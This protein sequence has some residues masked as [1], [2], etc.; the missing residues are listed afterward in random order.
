[1]LF[2]RVLKGEIS[3]RDLVRMSAEELASKELAAW[4]QRENRHVINTL[5]HS[6]TY[7][8]L[9]ICSIF[10]KFA[11]YPSIFDCNCISLSILFADN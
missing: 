9:N 7:F 3:P 6:D 5:T 1:M 11:L 2:K 8:G 10:E 4:R